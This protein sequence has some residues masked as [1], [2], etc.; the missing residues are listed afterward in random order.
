MIGQYSSFFEQREQ[1]KKEWK[2]YLEVRRVVRVTCRLCFFSVAFQLGNLCFGAVEVR[3]LVFEGFGEFDNL[4]RFR[5]E[6]L[7]QLGLCESR[8]PT[9]TRR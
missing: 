2:A 9:R 5:E 3:G 1:R 6:H 4:F 7:F 8:Q